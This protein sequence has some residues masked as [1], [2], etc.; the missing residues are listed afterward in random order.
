MDMLAWLHCHNAALERLGGVPAVMRIDNLKT[1][2][3][4][5]AGPTA[6]IN[7]TYARYAQAMRFHVDP[8]ERR[9]GNAKGKVEAKVRLVRLRCSPHGRVFDSLEALQTW[10]DERLERW[11]RTAVC[12]ITGQT[13]EATWREEIERL[14]VLPTLAEPFEAVVTRTVWRDCTV[15]FE[16][17]RYTVPF[18]FADQRIEVR[19]C[20]RTVEFWAEGMCV[21]MWRSQEYPVTQFPRQLLRRE[22]I[23]AHRLCQ[24][25]P[26]PQPCSRGYLT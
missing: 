2:V 16:G 8:C 17:R 26:R 19:A 24:H 21:Q 6:T 25:Q 14:Q 18:R 5:G 12:P 1:G 20:A 4:S 13:V 23:P 22:R 3:V 10:T 11:T 7:P 15:H 9:A